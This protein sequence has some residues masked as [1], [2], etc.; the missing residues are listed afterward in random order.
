MLVIIHAIIL[1]GINNSMN[2]DPMPRANAILRIIL[3]MVKMNMSSIM[4][5]NC[6]MIQYPCYRYSYGLPEKRGTARS[7]CNGTASFLP[8]YN[9]SKMHK[10][11]SKNACTEFSEAV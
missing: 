3:G 7:E 2:N 9:K 8:F 1:F 10:A 11:S 5:F 6:L 4:K